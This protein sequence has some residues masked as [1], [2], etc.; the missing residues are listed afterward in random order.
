[1]GNTTIVY[2]EDEPDYQKLVSKVLGDAGFM[3]HLAGTGREGFQLL[4]R[5]TPDLHLLDINLPDISGFEV[6]KILREDAKT[7]HIP[8]VALSA[9]AMPLDIERGLKAGF[10]R[11]L[12]KPIKINEF[13]D[14]LDEAL[15]LAEKRVSRN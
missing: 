9:N 6:L 15:N 1:M 13:F 10:L 14:A 4:E 3:I 5:Q 2:V 8:V 11:Y 7:T 12:T